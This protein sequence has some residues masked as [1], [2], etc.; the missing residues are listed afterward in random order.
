MGEQRPPTSTPT[1][2]PASKAPGLPPAVD[3]PKVFAASATVEQLRALDADYLGEARYAAV[4]RN[5]LLGFQPRHVGRHDI[6][7]AYSKAIMALATLQ[8]VLTGAAGIVETMAEQAEMAALNQQA[9]M[10]RSQHA[11]EQA[12][13]WADAVAP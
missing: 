7:D 1:S 8:A 4:A 11:A 2:A 3:Y 9:T 6:D 10:A 5:C 13:A 12:E